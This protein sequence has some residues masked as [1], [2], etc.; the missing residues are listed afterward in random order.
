MYF[1]YV[2]VN[3]WLTYYYVLAPCQGR[4]YMESGHVW[5]AKDIGMPSKACK[6]MDKGFMAINTTLGAGKAF[7]R[8]IY[9]L[10]ASWG[11]DFGTYHA[12]S[13][14]IQYIS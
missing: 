13:Q 5:N 1:V 8:S 7:L 12:L 11:I 9:E 4:P 3:F 10:Y 6:W 14:N 2:Q